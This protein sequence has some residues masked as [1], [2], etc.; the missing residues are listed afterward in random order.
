MQARKLDLKPYATLRG[1]V[2]PPGCG[3]DRPRCPFAGCPSRSLLTANKVPPDPRPTSLI[4]GCRPHRRVMVTSLGAP[5]PR[6]HAAPGGAGLPAV[7]TLL[8]RLTQGCCSVTQAPALGCGRHSAPAQ[9]GC[10]SFAPAHAARAVPPARRQRLTATARH[11]GG[12]ISQ[13]Q[14]V[15]GMTLNPDQ[16]AAVRTLLGSVHLSDLLRPQH[17]ITIKD[18]SS[19]DQCL[20]VRCAVL[21][22]FALL[23]LLLLRWGRGSCCPGSG[24]RCVA[25]RAVCACRGAPGRRAC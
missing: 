7:R 10:H 20:R 14:Q 9:A 13:Q 17:V 1:H 6:P 15:E 3:R 24:A 22:R 12:P 16:Q 18:S 8:N 19:V 2:T 25:Q 4:S 5:R 23:L 11:R 21:R